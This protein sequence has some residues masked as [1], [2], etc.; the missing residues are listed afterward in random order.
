[1]MEYTR[2]DGERREGQEAGYNLGMGK[3]G[4]VHTQQGVPH[5]QRRKTAK[6]FARRKEDSCLLTLLLSLIA[7][8]ASA[9]NC[10]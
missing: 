3:G 7:F 10:F 6:K 4:Y 1:M 2:R 5:H 8:V 9:S